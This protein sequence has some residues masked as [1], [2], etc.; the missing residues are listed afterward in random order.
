MKKV[1]RDNI[2]EKGL[3]K[4]KPF[5]FNP[6]KLNYLS[7]DSKRSQISLAPFIFFYLFI[8]ILFL[9]SH[10]EIEAWLWWLIVSHILG[11]YAQTIRNILH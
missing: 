7:K 10:T 1:I 5:L 3:K 8:S 4:N 9:H 11:S 6:K 2:E